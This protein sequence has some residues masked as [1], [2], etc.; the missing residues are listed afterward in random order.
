MKPIFIVSILILISGY[1]FSQDKIKE[2]LELKRLELENTYRAVGEFDPITGIATV[3]DNMKTGYIDTTGKIILPLGDYVT[4]PFYNGF[5]ILE[6]NAE[7]FA[8]NK[9]GTITRKYPRL[10]SHS[11]FKNGV[12]VVTEKK[13]GSSKYG[14]VDPNGQM[15]IDCKYEYIEKISTDYYYVS[16]NQTGAGII[17]KAGDTI[18]PLLYKI[19]YF[20]TATQNFIGLDNAIGYGIFSRDGKPL[21]LLVKSVYTATSYVEGIHYFQRDSLIVFKDKFADEG[22]RYTILNLRLDT[23]VPLGKHHFIGAINE[24]LIKFSDPV[25]T[26]SMGNRSKSNPAVKFGFLDTK[27]TAVIAPAFDFAHYFTEGLSGVQ[28]NNKWGFINR[29]GEIVVPLTF[30]YVLPFKSGYAKVKLN[31]RFYIIDKAG[32]IVLNSTS[33]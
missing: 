31:D 20:D 4:H 29:K 19:D 27:G 25:T 10:L 23:V 17:D 26:D 7:V 32:N 22:A 18:I 21:K 14:I 3:Y 24:G 11:Y 16:N 2:R 33:F 30:D 9:K 13:T 5:G 6:K 8:V 15:L 1:S 28:V 12:A